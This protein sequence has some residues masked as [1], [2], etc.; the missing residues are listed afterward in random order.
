MLGELKWNLWVR[1]GNWCLCSNPGPWA[2]SHCKQQFLLRS[3]LKSPGNIRFCACRI[4]ED[5]EERQCEMKTRWTR[6]PKAI[7]GI[8]AQP[9]PECFC[10]HPGSSWCIILPLKPEFTMSLNKQTIVI[11]TPGMRDLKC[12]PPLSQKHTFQCS[13]YIWNC[14]CLSKAFWL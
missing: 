12:L 7:S 9:L 4:S 11:L 13:I 5:R 3:V 1:E 8:W 10:S 2:G 6:C 14:Y